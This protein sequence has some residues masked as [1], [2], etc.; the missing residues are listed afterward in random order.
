MVKVGA[1]VISVGCSTVDGKL[2]GD[3]DMESMES[4]AV[5]VTPTPGGIGPI[6]TAV[7]PRDFAKWE[8]KKEA[9][10]CTKN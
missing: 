3:I 6:C 9:R 7:M 1:T 5:A 2:C 8:M 10:R 4:R